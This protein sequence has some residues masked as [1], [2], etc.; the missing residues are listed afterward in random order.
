[1][2]AGDADIY[3]RCMHYGVKMFRA[4]WQDNFKVRKGLLV[5]SNGG[6]W[7]GGV[8]VSVCVTFCCRGARG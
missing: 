1:M 4:F 2:E 7:Y 5:H 8:C 6:D 3:Y